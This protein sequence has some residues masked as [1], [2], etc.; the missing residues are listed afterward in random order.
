MS[1]YVLLEILCLPSHEYQKTRPYLPCG[2]QSAK[3]GWLRNVKNLSFPD[4]AQK[5]LVELDIVIFKVTKD[6]NNQEFY[7]KKYTEGD[8]TDRNK[9]KYINLPAQH[10]EN[11]SKETA[12]HHYKLLQSI[13]QTA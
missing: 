6:Q 3:V 2:A 9:P 1:C 12:S 13:K 10:G 5:Q 4:E 8:L 11:M 7:L